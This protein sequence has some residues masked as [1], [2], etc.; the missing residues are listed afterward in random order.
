MP[1]EAT[2]LP[3]EWQTALDQAVDDTERELIRALANT[4]I[5][6]PVLGYETDEGEII[7]LA[8]AKERVGVKFD[9]HD[10]LDGW[11]LCPADVAQIVAALQTSEVN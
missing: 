4:G 5:A 7:H 8:W 6:V 3:P 2:S 11:T 9:G 1:A 10:G